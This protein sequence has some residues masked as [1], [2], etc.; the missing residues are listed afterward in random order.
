MVAMT[1]SLFNPLVFGIG[2][3]FAESTTKKPHFHGDLACYPFSRIF[4]ALRTHNSDTCLAVELLK[5]LS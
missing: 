3:I 5:Y 1:S 2:I 4:R